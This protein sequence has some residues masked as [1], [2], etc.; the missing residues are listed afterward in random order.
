MSSR[1]DRSD[2]VHTAPPDVYGRDRPD[3]FMRYL[4]GVISFYSRLMTLDPPRSPVVPVDRDLRLVVDDVR[5]EADDVR[6]LRLVRPDGTALPSWRP[7]AHVDLVLPS[8]RQRQYSLCGDPA[9][10]GSYRIAIRRIDNG[11]GGSREAHDALRAGSDV[12][13]RGPRNAFPLVRADRY[14]FIAGGIGITPILPMVREVAATTADWRF[15]YCGRS[16]ESMPFLDEIAE[17]DPRRSWIRPDSDYGVPVS[18]RELLENAQDATVYCCGPSP[19]LHSVR[20]DLATS[21]AKELHFERFSAAPIVDGKPFEVELKRSGQVLEVPANR[22]ALEVIR[23]AKPDV[24]YSCQQGF[25][26]TC[27]V[28]LLAGSP[29]HHD[30]VHT[31][32]ERSDAI[33]ICV[34]RAD[35]G[36][37]VLDL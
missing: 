15:V 23:D 31:D 12:V 9:D 33:M 32:E 14:L 3:R 20:L 21:R 34:S 1:L 11:G 30:H 5:T 29:N 10:H 19:L 2:M 18:G 27:K 28:R 6:S 8:G 26:G 22:S 17:L 7:G 16:R 36:R 24:P 13:V 4:G 25:C 35:R 37:L